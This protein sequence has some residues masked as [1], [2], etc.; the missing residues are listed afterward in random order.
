MRKESE[1]APEIDIE[2]NISQGTEESAETAY[3]RESALS[4]DGRQ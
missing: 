2:H 3:V 4:G 1:Q